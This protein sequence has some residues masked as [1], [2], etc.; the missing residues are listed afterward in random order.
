MP[1]MGLCLLRKLINRS[2]LEESITFTGARVLLYAVCM[3]VV[4]AAA[5]TQR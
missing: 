1:L 2:K 4:P 5:V 3:Q